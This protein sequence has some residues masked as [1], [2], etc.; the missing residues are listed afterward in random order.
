MAL[1]LLEKEASRVEAKSVGAVLPLP[2]RR[3]ALLGPLPD[4]RKSVALNNVREKAK[5]PPRMVKR[6]IRAIEMVWEMVRRRLPRLAPNAQ[7]K[8]IVNTWYHQL[9]RG[10]KCRA[11]TGE[12]PPTLI[13]ISPSMRCDLQREGCYAAEYRKPCELTRE[14][15]IDVVRQGKEDFGIHF[16]T[17][18]GGEPTAWPPMWER[19][20]VH[21]GVFFQLYTHRQHVDEETASRIADLGN[22]TLAISVEEGTGKA[23]SRRNSASLLFRPATC[24]TG[25]GSTTHGRRPRRR[26]T[27]PKRARRMGR[28][29]ILPLPRRRSG[30]RVQLEMGFFGGAGGRRVRRGGLWP[31]LY[32]GQRVCPREV[33]DYGP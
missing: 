31:G 21:P 27:K 19:I 13:V 16:Y 1:S 14:E 2:T 22:V 24:T 23:S 26:S 17:I 25:R 33:E 5:L 4:K 7:R 8:L 28:G 20:E 29:A 32:A 3:P 10:E 9:T 18:L 12:R 15:F 6:K 11:E 30:V